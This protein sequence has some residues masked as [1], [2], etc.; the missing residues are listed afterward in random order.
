MNRAFRKTVKPSVDNLPR[1]ISEKGKILEKAGIERANGE[2]EIILCYLLD[3]G[4]LQ[5]YLHG[6][7]LIDDDILKRFDEIMEKRLTRYPLQYILEESW[8]YGR[9][10]FV[11]PAVMVPTPETELLCE[12]ALRFI[13]Q[14]GYSR[15]RIA[16]LGV[17][18]GVISVT[19]AK[20]LPDCE[21]LAIDVSSDA[22]EV[23][24]KNADDLGAS[25]KITFVQSDYFENI[26]DDARFDLIMANPPYISDE[27]YKSLPPE[28]LADPRISLTSGEE[29]LDAVKTILKGAPNYL[30]GGGR[31]MFEIGYN[32]ADRVTQLTAE[33]DRYKSIVILKDLNDIDRVV[34]LACD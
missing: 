11:S 21:I 9:K 18:S 25:E 8:F 28:V 2:V 34:I 33:D 32:Q 13:K 17:G 27:E 23:A 7:T 6:E 26:S 3:I 24:R 15:P 4:R 20:E 1:F 14:K 5:L 29:G 31:I 10:F 30:A 22:I 19:M 16:D 12:S